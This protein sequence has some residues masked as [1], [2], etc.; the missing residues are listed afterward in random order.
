M[1]IVN[2]T[3]TWGTARRPA[4][5]ARL[6][7]THTYAAAGTYTITLTVAMSAPDLDHLAQRHPVSVG[8]TAAFTFS[9][10]GRSCSV[11]ASG[12]TSTVAITNYHWDWKRRERDR[13]GVDT[14]SHTYA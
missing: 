2:Y 6:G 10:T 3:W 11:N 9:C 5:G 12:S 13:Y 1:G 7:P 14:A 4:V 8:P